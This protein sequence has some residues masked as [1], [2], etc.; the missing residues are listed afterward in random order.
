MEFEVAEYLEDVVD[1]GGM[2]KRKADAYY[3]EEHQ[4]DR[5]ADKK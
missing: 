3:Q 2:R 4:P 1:F 5:L